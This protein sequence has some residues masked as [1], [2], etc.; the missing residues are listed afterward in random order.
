MAKSKELEARA[1]RAEHELLLLQRISRIMAR[2][3]ADLQAALHSVVTQLVDLMGSTSA[4]LYL[5][6]GDELVLV[7]SN[8]PANSAQG[9]VRLKFSEGLTGW[10]AREKRLL[11][12]SREAYLDPRFKLFTDLPEDT[13]E[14]FLSAPVIARNQVIGVINVQHQLPHNHD[15]SEME[16]LTTVGELIG[17][18]LLLSQSKLGVADLR[19]VELVLSAHANAE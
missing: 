3:V 14:A 8:R 10:V 6:E 18:L 5:V 7:A 19:A 15:G 17:C 13:F 2:D 11:A 16:I 4:L 1:S 9:K 12:I